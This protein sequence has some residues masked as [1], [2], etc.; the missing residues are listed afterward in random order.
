[1]STKKVFW[2]SRKVSLNDREKL[3]GH[4]AC[5]VWFTGLSGSGKSS[6]ACEVERIL[7]DNG[8]HTYLLDGDYVRQGLSKDLGFSVNDRQENIRRIAEVAKLSFENGL[9][10]LISFI[11]PFNQ[12]RIF[13]RSLIRKG[14]FV[15]VYVKCPLQTCMKRDT[16]GLYDRALKGEIND[17]TGLTQTYEEPETPEIVLDTEDLGV[18]ESARKV[19]DYLINRKI[20][21]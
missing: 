11:S 18:G 1:M 6:I 8:A 5:V 10:T 16:K 4:R 19:V 17:F 21:V 3:N 14:F 2:H 20:I 9:I 7:Y 13:A 15:E 12:D